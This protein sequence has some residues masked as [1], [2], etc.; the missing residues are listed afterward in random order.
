MKSFL[1]VI[2]ILF[3][4]TTLKGQEEYNSEFKILYFDFIQKRFINVND[5]K[6]LKKGDSYQIKV[7]HFNLNNYKV[8]FIA[9]DKAIETQINSLPVFSVSSLG[10]GITD[11]L[12]K[13]N[14]ITNAPAPV[15]DNAKIFSY[16]YLNNDNKFEKIIIRN[17]ENN[18][19]NEINKLNDN[20]ESKKKFIITKNEELNAYHKELLIISNEFKRCF[21]DFRLEKVYSLNQDCITCNLNLC[22]KIDSINEMKNKIITLSNEIKNKRK[23]YIENT[24]SEIITKLI[25]DNKDLNNTNKNLLLAFE[26][27]LKNSDV[28]FNDL[29]EDK[30]GLLFKQYVD[31]KNNEKEF[32][33]SERQLLEDFT[34]IE[35]QFTPIEKDSKLESFNAK[36]RFPDKPKTFF[37]L[38]TSFYRAD[39]RDD[40]YSTR[41][42]GTNQFTLVNE[43]NKSGEIGVV[44]L[45]HLCYKPFIDKFRN[46]GFSIATGPALSL[47]KEIKPRIAIGGG[48]VYGNKNMLTLNALYMVGNEN[49]LSEAFD[50]TQT[51]TTQPQNVTVAKLSAA[52]AISLGYIYQF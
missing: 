24:S 28:I 52:F 6:K 9:D 19:N 43:K 8:T 12:S 39:F 15:K 18:E 5:F 21:L 14:S 31:F 32:I 33:T 42:D 44:T 3:F 26:E 35:L 1:L 46:F 27:L 48:L 50:E 23:E 13:I 38:S 22:K 41:A 2:T 47:S 17:N 30:V 16:E 51:Y 45:L 49:K 34:T 7:L 4:S 37:G 10:S 36:W 11:L 25:N 20:I 40:I 29:S